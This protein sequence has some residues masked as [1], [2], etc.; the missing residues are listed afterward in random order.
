MKNKFAV[1]ADIHS[2]IYALNV[3]IDYIDR[4]KIE[5]SFK[6]IFYDPFK[7]FK[8]YNT[9]RVPDRDKLLKIFYGE[10]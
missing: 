9:N 10:I 1:I 2:N 6:K 3:F 5:F 7:L 8:D 4:E